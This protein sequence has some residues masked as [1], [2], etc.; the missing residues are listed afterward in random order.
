MPPIPIFLYTLIQVNRAFHASID[1][2][3]CQM[4]QHVETGVWVWYW[5]WGPGWRSGENSINQNTTM[6]GQPQRNLHKPVKWK[7]AN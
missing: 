4:A 5:D 1:P 6:G 2:K 7:I 3:Q